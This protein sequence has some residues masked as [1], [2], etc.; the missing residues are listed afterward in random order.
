MSFVQGP[1]KSSALAIA[2]GRTVALSNVVYYECGE[3]GFLHIGQVKP[4][5]KLNGKYMSCVRRWPI[6]GQEIMRVSAPMTTVN[7]CIGLTSIVDNAVY[8]KSGKIAT[9]L[10][11]ISVRFIR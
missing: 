6:L 2:R 8:T 4:H 9:V 7:R 10:V 11:P 1:L 3:D 5:I